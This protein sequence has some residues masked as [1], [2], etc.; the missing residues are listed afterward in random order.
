MN[1]DKVTRSYALFEMRTGD[2]VD[3]AA[4]LSIGPGLSVAIKGLSEQERLV[5]RALGPLAQYPLNT[6]ARHYAGGN[7]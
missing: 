4:Q 5:R 6:T 2:G 1:D 3:I 7:D